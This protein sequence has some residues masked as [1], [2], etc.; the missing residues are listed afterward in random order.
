MI[1]WIVFAARFHNHVS[2]RYFSYSWCLKISEDDNENNTNDDD[3]SSGLMHNKSLSFTT[4]VPVFMKSNLAFFFFPLTLLRSGHLQIIFHVRTLPR[5]PFDVGSKLQLLW[6][7]CPH[8]VSHHTG[9]M[10]DM[11]H[12]IRTVLWTTSKQRFG[13]ITK[14]RFNVA[15]CC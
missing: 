10:G 2:M 14:I 9:L 13:L 5:A 15:F 12:E 7:G 3:G 6:A 8:R 1:T 11:V 4:Y